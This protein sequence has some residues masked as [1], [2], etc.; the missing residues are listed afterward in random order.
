MKRD[1]PQ[2]MSDARCA[3]LLRE[4]QEEWAAKTSGVKQLKERNR[5]A[6]DRRRRL[7]A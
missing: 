6:A 1:D 5:P 7:A 4:L 3:K 2:P